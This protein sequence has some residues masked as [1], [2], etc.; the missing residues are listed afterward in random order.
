MKRTDR[1]RMAQPSPVEAVVHD[2]E[3]AMYFDGGASPNSDPMLSRVVQGANALL[4]DLDVSK[5]GND[6]NAGERTV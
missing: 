6:E 4:R 2:P 1:V 3:Y 5:R